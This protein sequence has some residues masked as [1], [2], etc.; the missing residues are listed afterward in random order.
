MQRITRQLSFASIQVL[1]FLRKIARGRKSCISITEKA[2]ILDQTL[3]SDG[4]DAP[5]IA[6]EEG[7]WPGI[8]A[9]AR[10]PLVGDGRCPRVTAAAIHQLWSD[11]LGIRSSDRSRPAAT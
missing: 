10:W 6:A 5:R 4:R 3:L 11:G 8:V 9:E 7:R 1:R 2:A